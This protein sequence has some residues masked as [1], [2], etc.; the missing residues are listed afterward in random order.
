[1]SGLWST[2]RCRKAA[3]SVEAREGKKEVQRVQEVGPEGTRG[4]TRGCKRE[5]QRA[6]EGAPESTRGSTRER[7]REDQRAQKGGPEGTR[8]GPESTIG[9]T[10]DH[11]MGEPG[12]HTISDL[13]STSYNIICYN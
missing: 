1:M 13:G 2:I 4:R 3:H 7:K 10:R 5:G 12:E 11:K 9:V 8:V 6:Q